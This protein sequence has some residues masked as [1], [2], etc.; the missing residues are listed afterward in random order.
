M[1]TLAALAISML[2]GI[3]GFVLIEKMSIIDALYMTVITIS[4]VGYGEVTELSNAGRLFVS[5]LIITNIGV[6]AY[7]VTSLARF[8]VQGDAARILEDLFVG[9]KIDKM[10]NHIIVCGYGRYGRNVI[11]NLLFENI[12]CV[13]I[14]TDA[15]RVEEIRKEKT[16]TVLEGDATDERILLEAGV[17]HALALITTL[18]ED[19][20]N[21]YTVLTAKQL[22]PELKIVSRANKASSKSKLVRAGADEVLVPESIGGFFMSA[23]VTKPD[24]INV[25]TELSSFESHSFQ[26]AEVVFDPLPERLVGKTLADLNLEEQ[27]GVKIIGMKDRFDHFS[28]NP[29]ASTEVKEGIG[30][31]VIGNQ[32]QL[33]KFHALTKEFDL[34]Q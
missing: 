26:L 1:V 31:L 17:D 22:N 19:A 12:Q 2:I 9:R 24:I 5:F 33:D 11:D 25:F 3:V 34:V 7:A 18:P 23:M 10:K 6:F 20:D 14:E 32:D 13:L 27:S 15:E 8:F 21:V 4:T 28:V 29:T 30:I 16:I